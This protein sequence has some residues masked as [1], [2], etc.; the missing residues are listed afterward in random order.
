MNNTYSTLYFLF[1]INISKQI[2]SPALLLPFFH[3]SSLSSIFLSQVH[4]GSLHELCEVVVPHHY[5]LLEVWLQHGRHP[6]ILAKIKINT[7]DHVTSHTAFG[8][9]LALFKGDSPL[10][11]L[12]TLF[13]KKSRFLK[14]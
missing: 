1:T 6:I 4:K 12:V 8:V 2:P 9:I 14:F 13:T 7:I 3:L 10:K 5:L 11:Y